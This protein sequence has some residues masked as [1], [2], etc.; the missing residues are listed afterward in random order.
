VPPGETELDYIPMNEVLIK[1]K[2]PS[3]VVLHPKVKLTKKKK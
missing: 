3:N 2:K 1:R